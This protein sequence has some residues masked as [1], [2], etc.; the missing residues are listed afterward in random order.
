M[1]PR[2]SILIGAVFAALVAVCRGPGAGAAE[3]GE[4]DVKRRGPFAFAQRPLV[5][6]E[7][8]RV[9]IAFAARAA[10]DATVAVEGPEGRIVRHLASGVL[11]KN[12]PPPFKK[13][14]LAQTVVWDGKDDAGVYVDDKD[15]CTVR[16][17][18][19]L[20]P[21]FERTLFWSPHKRVGSASPV[22]CATPEGVYVLEN[23]VLD[24]ASYG[25]SQ[26]KVFD[27][28]GRYL[29]TVYPF[30]RDALNRVV[31]LRRHRFPGREEPLP[32]KH[33]YY[34]AS[35]LP[36]G[37]DGVGTGDKPHALAA[38]GDRIALVFNRLNRLTPD[39]TSGGRPLAGPETCF[40]VAT[41]N[42]KNKPFK[43]GPRSAA[44]GPDGKTL[45]LTGFVWGWRG[46]FYDWMHAV[47]KL[48]YDR[49][50]AMERF[51]GST[52][53]NDY[54]SGEGEF[55]VPTSV[56][57]DAKGR[58]YVADYLNDRIQVF[59]PDG[60][61]YKTFPVRRPAHVEVHRKTGEIYVFSWLLITR[62]TKEPGL[63]PTFTRLGPVESPRVLT[64]CP[65]PLVGYSDRIAWNNS[66]G[67]P[68]RIELDSWAKEPTLWLVP[69]RAVWHSSGNSAVVQQDW[70]TGIRLLVEKDGK[71]V[72]RR[73]FTVD[74]AR[75]TNR[76]RPPILWRQRL[77]VNPANEK[78]Y[79]GEADSGVAKSFNQLVEIA[80]Q[81]GK[82]KL[83][84]LPLGA[85]D[86]CFDAHERGYIRTGRFLV[87]YDAR[88]WREIP[89]DYGEP[90]EKHGWG[91]GARSASL[92]SG[93]P[94]PGHRSNP[95][96][97][98]GGIDV[99]LTGHIVVT[100]CN[101]AKLEDRRTLAEK[102]YFQWERGKPYTPKLYP[103]RMRWGEIH[104]YDQRGKV[105]CR[106]AVP[107]MG[108]LNGIGIDTDDYLYMLA[109]AKRLI[110]GK[111]RDPNLPRDASGTL[112]KVKAG[113]VRVLAAGEGGR[114]P[115]PISENG[116]P[117]RPPDIKGWPTGWVNGA[118][119]FY[120]GVGFCTPGGCICCNSRFDLDYFNR[121]FA[122]EPA[123]YS[124]AVL[125]SAGNLILRLGG[126][127]NVE[128]GLPLV[129]DGGPE[130]SR[131]VGGDEVAL[132]HACYVATHT[133][134]RLFIADQG[135]ARILSVKLDYH[136]TEKAP[137]RDG[138]EGK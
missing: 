136:V 97:H 8:D 64:R 50:E 74:A 135:N 43:I 132:M 47:M 24:H 96:W 113:E 17:S 87:R 137:L 25:G 122:P 134:R 10:C 39:G 22:I 82:I 31:G 95:F 102:R 6:R 101:L 37:L 71:L 84:D 18:L 56:A 108:H 27:H 86:I 70:Q 123:S 100:T 45:Y 19:G 78:L 32:L 46:H 55:K 116:R 104:V 1:R 26:L 9:R 38:C 103:G 20:K 80:P 48:D 36:S 63:K 98:L 81:T 68:Y 128:D 131:S 69:G 126:Y 62:L 124:V 21:R 30:P 117:D 57:C 105:V 83:E 7:G 11:G 23:Y 42:S 109:A 35:L 54:G 15:A 99:S 133:D 59:T 58:V 51:A 29:R 65:L 60:R 77:Y 138:E 119:W 91:M 16:V 120:G 33:G 4:C 73:N 121:S 130:A 107:G 3:P 13:H 14:S 111:Q 93:L 115:I 106:D 61:H 94:T 129:K 67:L 34:Q 79:V 40:S 2:P 28:D 76:V 5:T 12:A 118:E 44:F 110:G 49:G 53:V 112:L 88:N 66:G 52:K 41:P 72:A 92:I 90:R 85:E 75:K 125:D 114:I 127:G 89:F